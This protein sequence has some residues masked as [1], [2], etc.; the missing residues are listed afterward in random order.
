MANVIKNYVSRYVVPFYYNYENNG[1][2]KIL[3]YF[4]NNNLK[5]KEELGLP[6]DCSWVERGFWENYKLENAKKTEMDI[7]TY[8]L[9]I[10]KEYPENDAKFESNLGSSFLIK[11]DGSMI[12]LQYKGI[13][14]VSV[15]FRCNNLGVLIF[16]NGIGFIWYDIEFSKIPDISKYI[17]F[18]HDFKELA[19]IHSEDFV[20]KTGK[21]SFEIF[22][23]GKWLADIINAEQLGIKF[24]VEREISMEDCA[25]QKLIPDKALLFQY[26]F[27]EGEE[28]KRTD[29]AFKIANG[30][31]EKYNSPKYLTD[32]T[33][34]PFGNTCFYTSKA[35]TAYVV[36]NNASNETFFMDNFKGKFVRDYF[37]IYILLL[38]QTYSCAHYSR[39]LT[40]LPAVAERYE[41]NTQ[42]VRDLESLDNQINLFLVKSVYESVSNIQH[43]NGF[44]K[45]GKKV[46]SIHEDINSLTIG[47]SA[48]RKM[49]SEKIKS[50]EVKKVDK[51]DRALNKGLTIFG[52]LVVVSAAIDAVNLVDW[53]RDNISKINIGHIV[54]LGAIGILTIF[55][56]IVLIVNTRKK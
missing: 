31:G 54:S 33:F 49:E 14:E 8:L 20:K 41:K 32:D 11:T 13:K 3:E 26:L 15:G 53:F 28:L 19:R 48:L 40:K 17:K 25:K 29:L 30:Y 34:E 12:N 55:M 35:G 18:Q 51:K 37:F 10:Y 4:R 5:N 44:Y 36:S 46:L 16:R 52:F 56:F 2:S 1:Y 22:C 24:W 50:I 7:Y 21:E 42:Y 45:Y 47:L 9:Q 6:K 39:L 38:Y 43:Q 23:L 27:I